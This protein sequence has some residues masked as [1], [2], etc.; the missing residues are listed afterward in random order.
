MDSAIHENRNWPKVM[1]TNQDNSKI[2][3]KIWNIFAQK[4]V[5]VHSFE[6]LYEIR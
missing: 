1:S 3:I 4:K 2:N 5:K 6:S